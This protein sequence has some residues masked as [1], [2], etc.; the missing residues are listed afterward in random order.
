MRQGIPTRLASTQ[1]VL[2]TQSTNLPIDKNG[3]KNKLNSTTTDS[4]MRR[5]IHV[6]PLRSVPALHRYRKTFDGVTS[7]NIYICPRHKLRLLGNPMIS[8]TPRD[9][10]WT[11]SGEGPRETTNSNRTTPRHVDSNLPGV[12][13]EEVE[14]DFY[15]QSNSERKVQICMFLAGK[16]SRRSGYCE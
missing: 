6:K 5:T 12:L 9:T 16:R 8:M 10:T 1:D 15:L 11:R 14:G 13:H 7:N 4:F 3:H 2:P